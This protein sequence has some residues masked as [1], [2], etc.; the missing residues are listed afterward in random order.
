M[1]KPRLLTF[2]G[3]TQSLA[4]W[5]RQRGVGAGVIRARL[6]HG[7]PV[8]DAILKPLGTQLR[9]PGP[10][11]RLLTCKGQTKSRQEW[12]QE[13]GISANTIATRLAMGWSEEAA[14]LTPPGSRRPSG[15][16]GRLLTF[17][18][19]TQSLREWE[20]ERGLGRNAIGERLRK[21][22]SVKEAILTPRQ[23]PWE[24]RWSKAAGSPPLEPKPNRP[25]R[26]SK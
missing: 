6:R 11:P 17:R 26:R 15:R 23:Q 16:Q 10:P 3:R 21:G 8:E 9:K 4:D 2:R 14:I 22:W 7:W 13:K 12:A 1:S 24:R 18:G 5:A 25:G 19:R 20:R